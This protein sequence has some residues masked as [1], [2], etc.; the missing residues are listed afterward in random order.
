MYWKSNVLYMYMYLIIVLDCQLLGLLIMSIVFN[1]SIS[2]MGN[3]VC[4][5]FNY[6]MYM[7]IAVSLSHLQTQVN[8]ESTQFTSF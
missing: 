1:Q 3:S 7:S 4:F 2:C 5:S 8:S 6:C